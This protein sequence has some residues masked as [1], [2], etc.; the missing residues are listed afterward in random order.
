VELTPTDPLCWRQDA[1]HHHA[2]GLS[3]LF[4][5]DQ[6][7]KRVAKCLNANNGDEGFKIIADEPLAFGG[8]GHLLMGLSIEVLFKGIWL[9]MHS[10][11]AAKVPHWWKGRDGHK[12][13]CLAKSVGMKPNKA[14]TNQLKYLTDEVVWVGKYPSGFVGG[15]SDTWQRSFML[16]TGFCLRLFKDLLITFDREYEHYVK[17]HGL[18]PIA[19]VYLWMFGGPEGRKR[20]QG[21]TR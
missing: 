14:E 4:Q 3:I 19:K 13:L 20:A 16:H 17:K 18:S 5:Q 6:I 9:C 10:T 21:T 12:L 7:I 11:P 15:L 8:S 2:A 1:V